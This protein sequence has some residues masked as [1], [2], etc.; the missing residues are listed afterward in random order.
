[1]L[2]TVASS[3]QEIVIDARNQP[4]NEILIGIAA[5]ENCEI[6]FDDRALSSF[7]VT[8]SGRYASA[9]EA[10]AALLQNLPLSM[11]IQGGVILIIPLAAPG[12]APAS[13]LKG[14]VLDRRT[15]EPLP[16]A[17]VMAGNRGLAADL[18]GGF[19]LSIP[20][21]SAS[22]LR[23]SHLGYFVLDTI[24]HP[25]STAD[26]SAPPV[27]FL[28]T[29]G[30]IGLSEVE[31]INAPVSRNT[32][33]GD[34][35]GQMKLNQQIAVFLPG[36]GDNSV[37]NLLRLQP[38]ILAAGEQTNDLVIWG[39]YEGHSKVMFDGFTVYALKNF[40]DNISAF[41]PLMAKDIEVYKGGY[42]ARYGDRAGGIVNITGKNGN[43]V[44]P[45]FT[46]N[47]NNM[48]LN[49]MAEVPLSK[50]SSLVAAFRTTYYEL[51]NPSEINS[52][53]WRNRDRDTMNNV[54]LDIYP[55]YRFGDLNLKYSAL[56]R[57]SDLFFVSLYGGGDRFSYHVDQ[58]LKNSVL[59]KE[60]SER[61]RQSGGSVFY[62]RK[63]AKGS[64]TDFNFNYTRLISDY[65]D[66][67]TLVK[68]NGQPPESRRDLQSVNILR[69]SGLQVDHRFRP[70]R[71]QRVEAGWM[72]KQNA[73]ELQ[74]DTFGL[75]Q[76]EIDETGTRLMVYV[77]DEV[78]LTPKFSFKAGIR[79]NHALNLGK[80]Y[81]EPRA[82]L[83][84]RPSEAWKLNAA[85]GIY[86]QFI[87][88]SSV[89]DDLGN[90]RYLWAICDN[91]EVPVIRAMHWVGGV[92]FTKKGFLI[93][94]E[95]YYK[96]TSGLTRYI[97]NSQYNSEGIYEGIGR[98]Y[99]LDVMIRQD[100]RGHSAWVAYSLGRT[101][102]LFEYF[103]S[104]DY[105][106][107]PQDQRHE[108]K[109]ALLLN[110]EPFYFSVDY[111]YGSGF[112]PTP[113][114]E[115]VWDEN[116]D[117]SRLDAAFIY[118]FLDRKLKGEAGISVLNVLN[119]KNIKYANFERVPSGQSNTVSLYAEAIPITPALY[120]KL[121]L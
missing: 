104:N 118:K 72:Y 120:L 48:T 4:L 50:N 63:W 75:A 43:M 25:V 9:T 14:R 57:G 87:S 36:F 27:T 76:A 116:L 54:D 29:P 44:R 74:E 47:V 8:L 58:E 103:I 59:Q 102:E 92:T 77:Q 71:F 20:G 69:E 15:R 73:V 12:P 17:H 90:Y 65:S 37:F 86:D 81:A 30:M 108:I 110:F 26:P 121:S 79:L 52:R 22:T 117:Y 19:S 7:R 21:D 115:S 13:W 85:W 106:R 5:G 67:V 24:I 2:L 93:S 109:A 40:N 101:E 68:P 83:S 64:A 70:G 10:V 16:Y 31:I 94:L 111:V 1:M 11:E 55:D 66:R 100:Y 60:T 78:S 62:G 119:T 99:G 6:S 82:S 39:S 33:I 42:D 112:P 34:K 53:L 51:Y 23:I 18:A 95:G 91:E 114:I 41:N 45:S 98:S 56:F 107:A 61:N 96:E 38:G 32:I 35:A 97:R 105:R 113:F 49:S 89:I 80:F 46:L 88:R 3:A 28:L 84:Y